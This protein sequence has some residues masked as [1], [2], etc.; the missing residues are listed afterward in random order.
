M[1]IGFGSYSSGLKFEIVLWISGFHLLLFFFLGVLFC[2][3]FFVFVFLLSLL[4]VGAKRVLSRLVRRRSAVR[5]LIR[6]WRWRFDGRWVD[7]MSL[8]CMLLVSQWLSSVCLKKTVNIISIPFR[9]KSLSCV[10]FL[11]SFLSSYIR[12]HTFSAP[13]VLE[14]IKPQVKSRYSVF[15]LPHF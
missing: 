1:Q 11:I 8:C 13:W 12:D 7:Q 9:A 4:F 14:V 2:F 5:D 6:S 10:L 15:L 3:L